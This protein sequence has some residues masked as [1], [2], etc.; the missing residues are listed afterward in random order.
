MRESKFH[1]IRRETLTEKNRL[2][3]DKQIWWS[4]HIIFVSIKSFTAN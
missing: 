3:L 4:E 1:N 2:N